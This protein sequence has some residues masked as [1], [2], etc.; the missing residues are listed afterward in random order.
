M[1]LLPLL[2]SIAIILVNIVA[3]YNYSF[4]KD[5]KPTCQDYILNSYLYIIL[6]IVF[7][8]SLW[9]INDTNKVLFTLD[10]L[11]INLLLGTVLYL[12][13]Y[14]LLL[15]GI[16][17]LPEEYIG[18]THVLWVLLMYLLSCMTYLLYLI[19]VETGV[20]K[21]GVLIL[22][23]ITILTSSVGFFY[24]DIFS[25]DLKKYLRWS[26]FALIIAELAV[27]YLVN[28]MDLKIK[29]M[30]G[31]SFIGIII[32]SLFLLN[33]TKQLKENAEKCEVANYPKESVKFIIAIMNIFGDIIRI[34][35][36][37]KGRGKRGGR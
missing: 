7:I 13:V 23:V 19:G 34:L 9:I 29:L 17:F 36:L 32:F 24:G 2:I 20:I 30:I 18:L 35:A 11:G 27:F 4:D 5:N 26:L 14:I 28:D 37:T 21:M 3:I 16:Y 25:Q 33:Y 22:L 1:K 31:L 12:V 6:G 10:M 15:T 8:V